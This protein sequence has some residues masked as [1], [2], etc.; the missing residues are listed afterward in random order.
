MNGGADWL[1]KVS[2]DPFLTVGSAAQRPSSKKKARTHTKFSVLTRK[3]RKK[4]CLNIGAIGT[5]RNSSDRLKM[6]SGAKGHRF[7]S[8][9]AHQEFK[10]FR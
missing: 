6:A 1:G 5:C 2:T 8:C 4:F 10:G 9:T 7:E 3:T